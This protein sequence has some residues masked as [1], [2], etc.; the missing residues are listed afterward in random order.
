MALRA[1]WSPI[2]AWQAAGR[3]AASFGTELL[4]VAGVAPSTQ[5]RQLWWL[6]VRHGLS[7]TSYI[8]FQLYRP[9]RRT[10]AGEFVQLREFADISRWVYRRLSDR[11]GY[12]RADKAA[13]AGWCQRHRLPHVGS[14]LE[15]A[16]GEVVQG[17][18][19]APLP[20]TDLF[21]KPSNA[22]H[23]A[24]TARWI[25]DGEGRWRGEDG[26]PRSEDALRAAFADLSRAPRARSEPGTSRLLVQKRLTNHADLGPLTSGALCTMRILT[27]REP[28]ATPTIVFAAYRMAVGDVPAD[29]F[30]FGG[31]IAPIDLRTGRIGPALRRRT[32]VLEPVTHHPDTG[33]LIA[34]H[35]IPY[36]TESL[37]LALRAMEAAADRMAIGWDVATTP[38]GPVLIEG[39]T[40]SDPDIAQ[41]PSGIPLGSTP[42]PAS[43]EAHVRHY[44]GLQ[45]TP[46]ASPT[47]PAW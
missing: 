46:H 3:E 37:A 25:Y 17:D 28:G 10:R 19:H 8:D 27:C 36:W 7:A 24:G 41:A 35:Q 12:V 6:S 31:I 40:V 9:E 23:G 20:A 38:D 13:F 16:D 21:T 39:N 42:F 45:A 15:Y 43:L 14:V 29:N 32:R 4:E 5:R 1:L 18:P 30:H 2:S 11:D 22:A 33:A 47:A 44:L 26:E 34:G